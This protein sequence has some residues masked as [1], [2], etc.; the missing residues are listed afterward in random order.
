V[1]SSE[2][3][4]VVKLKLSKKKCQDAC[5]IFKWKCR[6]YQIT[7]SE[8]FRSVKIGSDCSENSDT[9]KNSNVAN[10]KKRTL[11]KMRCPI[12]KVS[13]EAELNEKRSLIMRIEEN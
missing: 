1:K 5:D 10:I 13:K 2:D 7:D 3:T 6:L 12:V 9:Q 4:N 8:S 11:K